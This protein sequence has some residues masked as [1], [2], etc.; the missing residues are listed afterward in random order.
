MN[1]QMLAAIRIVVMLVCSSLATR[2]ALSE[3]TAAT[4]SDPATVEAF[5]YAALALG[6]AAW[7]LWSRRPHGIIQDAA[8]LP[9]VN[10][11]L[12]KQK[13]ADEIPVL[14]VVSSLAEASRIP[15]VSAH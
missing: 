7:G 5:A 12:T 11:V 15:G 10:A 4:L 14:N 3:K 8:A 9:Q 13:T 2:G 1:A 6:A